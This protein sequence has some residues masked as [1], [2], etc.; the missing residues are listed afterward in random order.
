[1]LQDLLRSNEVANWKK[2]AMWR[3]GLCDE[4]SLV[5]RYLMLGLFSSV[6]SKPQGLNHAACR[7]DP[8]SPMLVWGGQKEEKYNIIGKNES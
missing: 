8:G 1:M 4:E 5:M 2:M 6:G 3:C 7:K